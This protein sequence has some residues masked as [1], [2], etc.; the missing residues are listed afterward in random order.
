MADA[1]F[2]GVDA[3]LV[4]RHRDLAR[5]ARAPVA[6]CRQHVSTCHDLDSRRVIGSALE[7]RQ[8]SRVLRDVHREEG[9]A[10]LCVTTSASKHRFTACALGQRPEVDD[11]GCKPPLLHARAHT[12]TARNPGR[13]TTPEA[14]RAVCLP[15]EREETTATS[16]ATA[17]NHMHRTRKRCHRNKPSHPWAPLDATASGPPSSTSEFVAPKTLSPC[18]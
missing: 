10:H 6:T 15:S 16:L 11:N 17:R 4:P 12:L 9:K 2:D 1:I 3:H 13:A 8:A 5:H 14:F 7:H 18:F